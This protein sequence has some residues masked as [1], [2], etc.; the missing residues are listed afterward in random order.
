MSV[1]DIMKQQGIEVPN[2]WKCV[3]D[4]EDR[5]Y[6]GDDVNEDIDDQND[7]RDNDDSESENRI[8]NEDEDDDKV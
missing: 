4:D 2:E 6:D 5:F 8:D 7:D 3:G 1:E